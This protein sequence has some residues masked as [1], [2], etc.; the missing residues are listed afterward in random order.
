M[1]SRQ[2]IMAKKPSPR[3]IILPPCAD[4]DIWVAAIE[5]QAVQSGLKVG[6]AL[7]DKDASDLILTDDADLARKHG[8]APEGIAVLL[9]E[10]GPLSD[11]YA[12]TEPN[13]SRHN[14]VTRASEL[15][16]RAMALPAD[17]RFRS[18]DVIKGPAH[19]FP[20]FSLHV[21][22]AATAPTSARN[23]ALLGAMDVYH[24]DHATWSPDLLDIYAKRLAQTQEARTFDV[25][26]KPRF[27]AHGPYLTM[28]SGHWKAVLR[29]GFAASLCDK[30]YRADWGG[31]SEYSK[32]EFRPEQEGLYEIEMD[33]LWE[34]PAPCEIRVM[35]MEGIFDGEMMIHDISISRIG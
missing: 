32:L 5:A 17:R 7:Q 6:T 19:L 31:V 22:K 25:T 30:G 11:E 18:W 13:P 33:W 12:S 26:G 14:S 15:T 2:L 21:A 34:Q 1:A 28:P 10:A 9:S 16:R 23:R 35:A 3:W 20:D 27:I 4:R 29:L 24:Q 8:A